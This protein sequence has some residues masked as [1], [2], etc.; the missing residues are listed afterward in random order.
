MYHHYDVR[1]KIGRANANG[2]MQDL[3]NHP[4]PSSNARP[5]TSAGTKKNDAGVPYLPVSN[6]VTT[7]LT[8]DLRT[9][10]SLVVN[11]T[12]P[13]SFF[14]PGYVARAV[15]NGVAHTYGEGTSVVQHD[16]SST[17]GMVN[18]AVNELVWGDQMQRFID[19]NSSSCGCP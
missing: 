10:G 18:W 13:G 16:K 7:Y 6:F 5:A 15:I 4:T 3:I 1:R 11:I 9:G 8:A 19:E 12:A 14:D 17:G 2:V